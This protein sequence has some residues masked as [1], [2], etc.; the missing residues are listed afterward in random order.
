VAASQKFIDA[1]ETVR[2]EID[3]MI[4][5]TTDRPFGKKKKRKLADKIDW[6]GKPGYVG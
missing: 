1:V 4:R 5:Q 2:P 6:K 3:T